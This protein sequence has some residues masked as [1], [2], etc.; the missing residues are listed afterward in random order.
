[1]EQR[2]ESLR[3]EFINDLAPTLFCA[4]AWI[5]WENHLWGIL[6]SGTVNKQLDPENSLVF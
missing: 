4:K 1:M 6:P 2:T 5:F 3:Q